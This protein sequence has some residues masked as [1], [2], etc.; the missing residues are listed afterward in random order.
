[1]SG[2]VLDPAPDDA[3]ALAMAAFNA[4]AASDPRV[5]ATLLTVRDGVT[6]IR[7]A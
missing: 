4:R 5:V 7:P 3:S 2:R 6:L 1:M